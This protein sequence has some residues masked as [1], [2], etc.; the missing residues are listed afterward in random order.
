LDTVCRF[1]DRLLGLTLGADE[2]DAAALGDGV[3]DNLQRL[4][5]HRNSLRQ[6]KDVNAVAVA[7]DVFTHLRVP[8]LRLVTIVN[9]SFQQLT[10]GELGKSHALFLSGFGLG[11]AVSGSDHSDPNRRT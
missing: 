2:Q 8:A 1:R 9:A 6:V 4:I 5:Q 7:V 10:H 11:E 3:A